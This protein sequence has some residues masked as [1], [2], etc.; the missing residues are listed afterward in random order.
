[1]HARLDAREVRAWRRVAVSAV[2][3]D[4]GFLCLAL[5]IALGLALGLGLALTLALAFDMPC[6]CARSGLVWSE[7]DG[8]A[9]WR[10]TMRWCGLRVVQLARHVPSVSR[11]S[12]R[13]GKRQEGEVS[14]EEGGLLAAVT[15][16]LCDMRKVRGWPGAE[17][18]VVLAPSCALC[19]PR[20]RPHCLFRGAPRAIHASRIRSWPC[21]PGARGVRCT[22]LA[23]W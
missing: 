19:E 15:A 7:H 13:E 23:T 5:D 6:G 9:V 2:G 17:G 16:E 12:E 14:E 1:M 22:P 20:T 4:F 21:G 8:A 10:V 18:G 11:R 3:R